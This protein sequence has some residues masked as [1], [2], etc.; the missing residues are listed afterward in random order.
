[1]RFLKTK[2]TKRRRHFI[3]LNFNVNFYCFHDSEIPNMLLYYDIYLPYLWT[4]NLVFWPHALT[5]P[6]KPTTKKAS[7]PID[8]IEIN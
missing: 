3:F 7:E 6:R 8:I 5:R 2:V 1:M 4:F